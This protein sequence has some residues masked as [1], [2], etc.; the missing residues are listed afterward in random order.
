M[1]VFART[2]DV[3]NAQAYM[4]AATMVIPLIHRWLG[5]EPRGVLNIVDLPEQ[6]D[7]PFRRWLRALHQCAQRRTV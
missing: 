7:A 5:T 6:G 4:T 2:E 3:A 1:A